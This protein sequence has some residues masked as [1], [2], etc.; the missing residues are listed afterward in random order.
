MNWSSWRVNRLELSSF[1]WYFVN[2]YISS[3][4][5]LNPKIPRCQTNR[6]TELGEYIQEH[7]GEVLCSFDVSSLHKI[8]SVHSHRFRLR[9]RSKRDTSNSQGISGWLFST[10]PPNLVRIEFMGPK[11]EFPPCCLRKWISW[12]QS[13]ISWLQSPFGLMMEPL[14][15][16]NS[17]RTTVY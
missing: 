10:C 1:L 8:C 17:I 3:L 4:F 6:G 2:G 9:F 7:P 16:I 14:Q 13:L 15:H 11:L 5:S 12:L